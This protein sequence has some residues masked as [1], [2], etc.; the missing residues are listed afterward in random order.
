M[1]IR[2]SEE[3]IMLGL[4]ISLKRRFKVRYLARPSPPHIIVVCCRLK[5][6]RNSTMSHLVS[7]K[8]YYSQ[9]C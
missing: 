1:K 7:G 4:D 6:R 9:T 3:E 8:Y 2:T 5:I